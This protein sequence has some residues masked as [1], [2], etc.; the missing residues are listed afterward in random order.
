[1]R[2]SFAA[3]SIQASISKADSRDLDSGQPTP[4]APRTIYDFLETIERLPLHLNAKGE[5]EWVGRT[6][7]GTGCDPRNV[8]AECA[9]TQVKEFRGALVRPFLHGRIEVGV[10]FLIARGY[11]GQTTE[12]FYP[13]TMQQIV[14]VRIPSHA[15]ASITYRFGALR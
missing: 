6:L 4:E 7:L 3:G 9:G 10:N 15:S 11:T 13:S 2:R 12:N 8:N 5:F 14:G 1:M